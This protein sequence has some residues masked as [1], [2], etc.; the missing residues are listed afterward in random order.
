MDEA[1]GG[2]D[3]GVGGEAEGC[4]RA[5]S[6]DARRAECGVMGRGGSAWGGAAGL[7]GSGAATGSGIGG[8]DDAASS[9]DSVGTGSDGGGTAGTVSSCVGGVSG[10]GGAVSGGGGSA[11]AP[12]GVAASRAARG[13]T[14]AGAGRDSGISI[15]RSTTTVSAGGVASPIPN[16][17]PVMIAH[18]ST[19]ARANETAM[20]P[21]LAAAAE[22]ARHKGCA[23]IGAAGPF[24]EQ[25]GRGRT[26]GASCGMAGRYCGCV[27]RSITL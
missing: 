27:S 26:E 2:A 1:A 8:M 14:A 25:T 9:A 16:P 24:S 6:A 7:A 3:A 18:C 17:T 10:A 19:D 15:A 4:A 23:R 5:C 22:L 11:M 21:R 13:S 20:R 12:G